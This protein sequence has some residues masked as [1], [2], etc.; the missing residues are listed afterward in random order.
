[1]S[2]ERTEGE[3]GRKSGNPMQEN[4]E[5]N[6]Y[7]ITKHTKSQE[8]IYN[9]IFSTLQNINSKLKQYSSFGGNNTG[10]DNHLKL[11]YNLLSCK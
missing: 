2:L 1:M 11:Y 6:S 8:K 3:G 4:V 5:K 7:Y 9:S 10:I